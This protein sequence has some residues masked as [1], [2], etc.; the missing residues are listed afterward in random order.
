MRKA[1]KRSLS[2]LLAITII[3][4]SA[5]VGLSEIDFGS[6]FAIETRV[7]SSGTTGA[8]TWDVY[9]TI[10]D[11]A[12]TKVM[13]LVISGNGA[14]GENF[15][16]TGVHDVIDIH[17]LV[18]AD[19]VT[20]ISSHAFEFLHLN[21]ITIPSSVTSIGDWAFA[22]TYLNSITIPS[23]VK[24]IGYNAFY[25]CEGLKDVYYIGSKSQRY[26]ISIGSYNNALTDANWHYSIPD[27]PKVKVV[28]TING[29][30]VTWN[31]VP[32]A[33][34][35]ALYKRLGTANSWTYVTTTTDTSYVDNNTPSAGS[36]YV[37]T[38]KAY[39]SD[40]VSSDYIK[41]NCASV[42]RVVAPYTYATNTSSGIN[43]TWGKV[44]GANK[45]VV[46]RRIGTES[47]WKTLYT[48][49]GTSF[50]DK[51]VKAGIYYLYSVRAVNNTG[52]SAYDINKRVTIKCASYT[53]IST[54]TAVATNLTNGVQVKWN[55]VTGAT[56]YNVYRRVGGSS[57]W[58]LVGTTTGTSLV[59]KK[60]VNGKYYAYS[61]RAINNI[62]YSGYDAS[63]IDIIQPVT[64]P[65][66]KATK[67]DDGVYVRWTIA[68]GTTKYLIY[69]R[70]GGTNTWVCVG[71]LDS[72]YVLP[73]EDVIY[74]DR[75]VT[76]GKYYT[77]S[78]RAINGTGYS[79]Y[80]SSKCATIKY[81]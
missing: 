33:V 75:S 35:Y 7:V 56:K 62:G 29:M 81:S 51:N 74:H 40:G 24:S 21:S 26:E 23:S 73:G 28:N 69:R 71:A 68:S 80:N 15:Y 16:F 78:I 22:H 46:L 55:S 44:A 52:Y 64:A 76:K 53:T 25:G 59:D 72:G 1:L 39:N 2:F 5:Y 58:V 77:Y 67:V 41:A 38:V 65:V 31:S 48:T 8:C 6:V 49:T 63:K 14:M 47:T 45:Y 27:T 9:E 4:G 10:L 57:S 19:G 60:I 61:V 42:Q 54:P 34:K 79:A 13:T 3:L 30:N 36:Y 12:Y 50:L 18:I 32:G 43:V 66:V 17:E 37:Y 70:L 20:Y 11:D